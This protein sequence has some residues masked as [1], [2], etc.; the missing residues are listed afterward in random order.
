MQNL[1]PNPEATQTFK[2]AIGAN[3]VPW[4]LE[5]GGVGNSAAFRIARD[6]ATN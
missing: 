6:I 4:K 3:L 2:R 5:R 1:H